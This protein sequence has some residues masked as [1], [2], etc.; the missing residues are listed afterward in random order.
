ML[1]RCVGRGALPSARHGAEFDSAVAE[2]LVTVD[3]AALGSP[4]AVVN[5]WYLNLRVGLRVD[6]GEEDWRQLDL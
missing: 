4:L 3:G 2:S 6:D 5:W 1:C